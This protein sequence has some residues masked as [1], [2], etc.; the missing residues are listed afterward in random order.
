MARRVEDMEKSTDNIFKK[1]TQ[2]ANYKRDENGVV[3]ELNEDHSDTTQNLNYDLSN[4]FMERI[5]I[6][7]MDEITS[8]GNKDEAENDE[9]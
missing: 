4:K 8:D 2:C 3:V 7:I 1:E 9:N 6:K 5:M